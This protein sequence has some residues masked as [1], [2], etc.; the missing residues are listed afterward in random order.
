M[1]VCKDLIRIPFTK[2]LSLD[3]ARYLEEIAAGLDRQLA[4]AAEIIS[5]DEF[6]QLQGSNQMQIDAFFRNSGIRDQYDQLINY[7][8]NSSEDLINEFYRIGAGL[9][10]AEIGRTL[11]FTRADREALYNVTQY[12]F[13]LIRK[14]NNSLREQI[15]EVIFDAVASGEGYQ[16]TARKLREL[17]LEPIG[18]VSVRTRAEMIARTEHA[19]ARNTGTLQAYADYGV[20]QVEIITAGD[21]I[22]CNYC[23]DLEADNPYTLQE[24]MKFLPAHPNCRCAYGAIADTVQDGVVDNPVV[25]DLTM[26]YTTENLKALI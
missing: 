22:V 1:G 4:L 16:V 18:N 19:R 8:A 3:E 20:T 24:A 9:G 21:S 15:R 25:V 12:N 2:A 10:F 5:S 6:A 17:P 14:L 7:N 23:L 13:D 26:N 11:A